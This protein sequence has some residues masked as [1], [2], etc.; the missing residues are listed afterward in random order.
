[1]PTFEECKA[2]IEREF[3]IVVDFDK[4]RREMD[5]FKYLDEIIMNKKYEIDEGAFYKAALFD[6]AEQHIVNVTKISSEFAYDYL[7]TFNMVKLLDYFEEMMDAR[8]KEGPNASTPRKPYNG[9]EKTIIDDFKNGLAAYD[10]PLADVWADQ[11]VND[12]LSFEDITSVIDN[13]MNEINNAL[14][15]N[16]S[17]DYFQDNYTSY[18]CNIDL[19]QKALDKAWKDRSFIWRIIHPVQAVKQYLY[20]SDLKNTL[21]T[22]RNMGVSNDKYLEEN[23][24]ISQSIMKYPFETIPERLEHKKRVQMEKEKEMSRK[25]NENDKENAIENELTNDEPTASINT[26][27]VNESETS[28]LHESLK[29]D[30]TET[31]NVEVSAPHVEDKSIEPPSITN[32][33]N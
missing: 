11:L 33:V 20:K 13:E 31:A 9:F 8:H 30:L 14:K 2:K 4:V 19:A 5:K 24:D 22:L 16:Q 15:E 27:E 26:G 25:N 21:N 7:N 23:D 28:K 3:N 6:F 32:T 29:D 1:M 18:I 12:K 17:A 10:K